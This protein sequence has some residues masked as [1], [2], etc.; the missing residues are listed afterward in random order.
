VPAGWSG[1]VTLY[2]GLPAGSPACP[3]TFPTDDYHGNA[4]LNAPDATCT[5]CTCAAPVGESCV[6]GPVTVA[7]VTC[8]ATPVC[9]TALAAPAAGACTG[10]DVLPGSATCGAGAG[11][12]CVAGSGACNVSVSSPAPTVTPGTCQGSGGAAT[13]TA[14]SW[15]TLGRACAGPTTV[16]T[17]CSGGAVCAPRAGPPFASGLCIEHAGDMAC[18]AGD[19]SAKH[20]FYATVSDTRGCAACACGASSGGTCSASISIYSSPTPNTCTG[21]L[22]TLQAGSCTNLVGNPTVGSRKATITAPQGG[23]CA[24][25]G[26]QPVGAATPGT[27][28]TFCCVP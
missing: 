12:S 8:G 5:T 6:P 18:P 20:L 9:T 15:G 23:S 13:V 3:S 14:P 2:D 4:T 21:G 28:T 19:F 26:G 17:G 22:I 10:A 7:D 11:P 25:S 24:P 16:G 1:Y 27:P